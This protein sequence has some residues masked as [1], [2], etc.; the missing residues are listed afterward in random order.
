[1]PHSS[2]LIKKYHDPVLSTLT[3][4]RSHSCGVDALKYILIWVLLMGEP[5]LQPL[6]RLWAGLPGVGMLWDWAW[7]WMSQ[8]CGSVASF[9]ALFYCFSFLQAREIA[10]RPAVPQ[11][12]VA[13]TTFHF[14]LL[15]GS[16]FFCFSEFSYLHKSLAI[17]LFHRSLAIVI[18]STFPT[19]KVMIWLDTSFC[20]AEAR[21]QVN[22]SLWAK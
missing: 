9:P 17:H 18:G 11:P 10:T 8:P 12:S 19:G 1:M 16:P 21:L 7:A 4:T 13:S 20:G 15:P 2:I 22:W 3:H 5:S 14:L 6:I